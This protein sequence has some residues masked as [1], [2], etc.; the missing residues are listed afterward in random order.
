MTSSTFLANTIKPSTGDGYQAHKAG[1]EGD[2]KR[3]D[4]PES[5]YK[6]PP[7]GEHRRVFQHESNMLP[8]ISFEF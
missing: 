5:V 4:E 6:N 7:E 3:L 8:L 2:V 1:E